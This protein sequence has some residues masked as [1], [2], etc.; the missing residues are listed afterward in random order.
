MYNLFLLLQPLAIKEGIKVC[1]FVV[2]K[3]GGDVVSYCD[4]KEKAKAFCESN[5]GFFQIEKYPM[6]K[7]F[8]NP[9]EIVSSRDL[10]IDGKL[11]P[12]FKV[13]I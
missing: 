3:E 11:V 4:S 7:S 6:N 9:M 10:I 12:A 5:K 1:V 2:R 8:R 13:P